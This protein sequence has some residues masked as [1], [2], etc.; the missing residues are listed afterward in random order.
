MPVRTAVPE[1]APIWIDLSTSD[2]PVSRAFYTALF[3]WDAEDPDPELG[4][5]LNF[6]VGGERVAGCVPAMPGAPSDVWSVYLATA[7]A[8]KTTAAVLAAGGAVHA[9]AMDVRDLGRMAI[10]ADPGAAVVGLWQ[11]GTHRGLLTLAEPG[12]AGWFELATR[13][14]AA[15]LAFVRDVFGWA[16]E[17]VSDAP[18][19]RYS[20]ASLDGAEVAGILDAPDAPA[21][22]WTVYFQVAD[23]DAAAARVTELG[24]T[25]VEPPADTPYGRTGRFLDPTGAPFQLVA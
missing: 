14:Y 22:H 25:V 20:V 8:E 6:S 12:R 9:P 11:P 21:A 2:Q 17:S 16:T 1:G 19:M 4:G 24:G 3:G 23:A 15:T 18:G 7:D 5:Y 10:V 13:D